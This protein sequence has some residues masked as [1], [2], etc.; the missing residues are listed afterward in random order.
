MLYKLLVLFTSSLLS[1]SQS[2]DEHIEA[3]K[4]DDYRARIRAAKALEKLGPKAEPAIPAL[5]E[6]LRDYRGDS[7]DVRI[8]TL[9]GK[10]LLA[11]GEPGR[12]AIFKALK[13][14]NTLTFTGAAQALT[15]MKTPPEEALPVL[16][17]AVRQRSVDTSKGS[18][19]RQRGWVATEVLFHYGSKA[20][21]RSS[22]NSSRCLAVTTFAN[23]FLPPAC[24]V[25]LARQ[26]IGPFPL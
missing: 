11:I 3:L 13:S 14:D 17:D 8:G 25:R 4:G 15:F 26:P 20:A 2:I 22:F 9:C 23:R 18:E 19:S 1:W 6:G 5:V 24:W 16:F 10:A 12:T 21:S 7:I